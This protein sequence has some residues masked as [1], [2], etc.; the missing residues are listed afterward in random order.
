MLRVGIIGL[1]RWGKNHLRIYSNMKN[2]KLVGVVDYDIG[3]KELAE[4]NN[5]KFFTEYKELLPLIDAVSI[6]TPTNTHYKVVK[7]CLLNNKH[8]L[9]EK[10][11]TLSSKKAK[12]L[13]NL[14]YDKKK[15]LMVGY[16]FRFN[17]ATKRLKIELKNIGKIN[18]IT[19]RFIHST[20]PPR[21]DCGVIFNFGIHLIDIMNFILDKNPKRVY[22]NKI[23]HLNKDR[24]DCAFIN[25]DYGSYKCNFEVSWLHPVKARDLWIIG[26]NYKLY[27]DL[28]EQIVVKHPIKISYDGNKYKKDINLEI[29]KNEPLKDELYYFCNSITNN[30]F[31]VEDF[32]DEQ[33]FISTKICEKCLES[34]EKGEIINV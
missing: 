18:Y 7:D 3:K 22:C 32:L 27:I 14:A 6:V 34:A 25:L 11:I 19:G 26:E 29:R 4:K 10:P 31:K 24:E 33:A 23:N 8:V 12:E 21:K 28:F 5:V 13:F 17:N 16:L 9:V 30:H 1:G 20:K 2:V 15:F